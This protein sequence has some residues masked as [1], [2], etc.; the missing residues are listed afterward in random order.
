MKSFTYPFVGLPVGPP[1][2]MSEIARQCSPDLAAG[3]GPPMNL[4]SMK[5]MINNIPGS[6]AG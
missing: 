4:E 1:F 6:P 3:V 5:P 2:C